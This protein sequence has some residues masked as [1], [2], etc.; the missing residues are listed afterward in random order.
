[1]AVLVGS[2]AADY[3]QD[4]VAVAQCIGKAFK[5]NDRGGFATYVSVGRHVEGMTASG[6]GQVVLGRPSDELARFQHNVGATGE[7]QIAF[8]FVQTA[9]R[10]M[11]RH[12]TGR[13]G[14][15][16]GQCGAVQTHG[17]GDSAGRHREGVALESV[18]AV[19]GIGIRVDQLIIEMRQAH[20]HTG[21]RFTHRCRGQT[22][23]LH[24]LP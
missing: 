10:H 16:E 15:V 11:H 14:G 17:I 12:E 22:R 20:E 4:P 24:G 9:A 13:T 3:R 18:R 23:V 1:M 8:A 19:H 2:R 7:G 5:Q 21:Q 6:G